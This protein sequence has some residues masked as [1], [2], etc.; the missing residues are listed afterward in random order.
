MLDSG[1]VSGSEVQDLGLNAWEPRKGGGRAAR[2]I[3]PS[4]N[5]I[6]TDNTPPAG[7]VRA[8]RRALQP[9]SPDP[10]KR[11]PVTLEPDPLVSQ[12]VR[13]E[14]ARALRPARYRISPARNYP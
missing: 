12:E 8:G 13:R 9:S 5:P 4:S 3:P 14:E 10:L 6:A 2:N 11:N 1:A 7:P